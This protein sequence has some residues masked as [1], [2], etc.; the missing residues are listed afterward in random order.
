M[1]HYFKFHQ[2]LLAPVPAKEVYVKRE[3]G[4]GWRVWQHATAVSLRDVSFT[5]SEAGR[6][7]VLATGKKNVHAF[8]VGELLSDPA[9]S[10][11]T[12]I[13]GWSRASYNPRKAATFVDSITQEPVTHA[14]IAVVG[15]AGIF[16][17]RGINGND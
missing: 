11:P 10:D 1:L 15:S 9:I 17:E 7:R 14:H 2:D 12:P 6:Q 13:H 16:I 8:M 4:K 5:V 3:P